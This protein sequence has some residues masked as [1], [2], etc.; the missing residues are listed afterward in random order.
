MKSERDVGVMTVEV[1]EQTE[2]KR[3]MMVFKR[4]K[5][6]RV[7]SSVSSTRVLWFMAF[8][9]HLRCVGDRT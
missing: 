3:E 8:L 5:A 6:E 4:L 1:K 2:K 9:G 7:F